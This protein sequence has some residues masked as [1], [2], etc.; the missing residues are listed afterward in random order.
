M[1]DHRTPRFDAAFCFSMDGGGS[2]RDLERPWGT[3]SRWLCAL[4]AIYAATGVALSAYAAHAAIG[5]DASRLQTAALFAFGHGVALAALGRFPTNRWT[6]VGLLA[7]AVGV[8]L[9]AGSLIGRVVL[10]WAAAFAP[11]GGMLL[12]GGWLVFAIGQWRR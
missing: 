5:A 10:H 2:M 1:R 12:I 8:A 3:G 9:F 11:F 4:G 7:I 6:F